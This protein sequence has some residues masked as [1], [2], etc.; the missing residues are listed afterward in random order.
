[1]PLVQAE[2]PAPAANP[3]PSSAINEAIGKIVGPRLHRQILVLETELA[4]ARHA[5]VEPPGSTDPHDA[6]CVHPH[7]ADPGV[8]YARFF[9]VHG[10]DTTLEIHVNH[11]THLTR[12]ERTIGRR[13][14]RSGLRCG[15][16]GHFEIGPMPALGI[17]PANAGV[18]GTPKDSVPVAPDLPDRFRGEALRFGPGFPV[19]EPQPADQ[20]TAV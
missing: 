13:L 17:E 3:E 18:G 9:S 14:E 5:T 4:A 8:G 1:M 11:A 6:L 19:R 15:Q 12:P 2:E 10:G 20:A 16:T 7:R